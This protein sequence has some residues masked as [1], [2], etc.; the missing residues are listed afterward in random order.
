MLSLLIVFILMSSCSGGWQDDDC[1]IENSEL[2][3]SGP[4]KMVAHLSSRTCD[5][6]NHSTENSVYFT[7]GISDER[8]VVLTYSWDMG[9]KPPVIT[10]RNNGSVDVEL[11]Y[12]SQVIS[13]NKPRGLDVRVKVDDTFLARE[14]RASLAPE[15]SSAV[16]P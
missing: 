5:G 2:P 16:Y 11:N 7:A 10:W 3:S 4:A 1:V 6:F 8:L 14:L 9:S 12:V 15:H 13:I